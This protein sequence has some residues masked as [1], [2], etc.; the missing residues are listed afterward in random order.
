M[1]G[2]HGWLCEGPREGLRA[3][4]VTLAAVGAAF[5]AACA[6]GPPVHGP[7][8]GPGAGESPAGTARPAPSV[9]AQPPPA[10]P[11]APAYAPPPKQ[12]HLGAPATALVQQAHAQA[13]SG[14]F[15]QAS[16]T[17]ERALRI[18]PDNPL[19]WI[20]LGRLRLGGGD[21]QQADSMGRKAL[22]LASGD[23]AAQASAWRLIADALQAQG[24]NGEAA[25]AARH[26]AS[27]APQFSRG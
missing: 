17:V 21:A 1:S 10:A 23:G 2:P 19:L 24:R 7:P 8:L 12:F 20:E 16:A 15:G 3:A 14:D 4:A 27:L 18:E 5:L 9:P 11:P 25:D 13:K 26:A 22:S 6:S